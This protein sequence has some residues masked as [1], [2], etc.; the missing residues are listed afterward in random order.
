MAA[1]KK[2]SVAN[3]PAD[4]W[5]AIDEWIIPDELR[6]V[7]NLNDFMEDKEQYKRELMRCRNIPNRPE[8]FRADDPNIN[9]AM[10]TYEHI[11]DMGKRE[12]MAIKALEGHYKRLE[13]ECESWGFML[14]ALKYNQLDNEPKPYEDEWATRNMLP[15]LT[16]FYNPIPDINERLEYRLKQILDL[17]W[18]NP[19]SFQKWQSGAKTYIIKIKMAMETGKLQFAPGES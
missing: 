1:K 5:I 8:A 18:A 10:E 2:K 15:G 13:D 6:V 7:V 14:A 9:V 11:P 12:E 3:I 19:G 17:M 4:A 16:T